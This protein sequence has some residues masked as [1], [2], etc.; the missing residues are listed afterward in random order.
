MVIM[1]RLQI[2]NAM[3]RPSTHA[4]NLVRL[5]L[6]AL[7]TSSFITL[8]PRSVKTSLALNTFD[9]S[10]IHAQ[11]SARHPLGC[12]RYEV[13]QQIGNF[14]SL[15]KAA[16]TRCLGKLPNRFLDGQAVRR[17]PFLK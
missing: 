14:L 6:A 10:S 11:G 7:E 1:P 17:R 9:L 15:S 13:A 5:L 12:G 4:A 3:L 8:S 16:D 2:T